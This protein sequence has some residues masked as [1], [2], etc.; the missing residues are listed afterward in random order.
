MVPYLARLTKIREKLG[1][2]G[3]NMEDHELVRLSINGFFN[4]W[5]TFFKVVVA[6]EQ[7]PDWNILWND[8]V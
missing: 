1:K 4:P 6:R 8:F 3:S 7:L 5:D 2:V